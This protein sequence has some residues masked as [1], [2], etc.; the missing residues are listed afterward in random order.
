MPMHDAGSTRAPSASLRV[1][2]GAYELVAP[3]ALT[4]SHA[5]VRSLARARM[6]MLSLRRPQG[7]KCYPVNPR[8][9]KAGGDILG[10][11][12]PPC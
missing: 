5:H 4:R 6:P 7:Y 1:R 10:Q 8:I 9:A 3:H 11:S 12:V 2:V